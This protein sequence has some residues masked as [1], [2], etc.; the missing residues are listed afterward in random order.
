MEKCPDFPRTSFSIVW[1]KQFPAWES[2]V[3][4]TQACLRFVWMKMQRIYCWRKPSTVQIYT[5][6]SFLHLFS[7]SLFSTS[8]NGIF[9][10][11]SNSIPSWNRERLTIVSL[12]MVIKN[13]FTIQLFTPLCLECPLVYWGLI[14]RRRKVQF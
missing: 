8:K 5:V 6:K 3:D 10:Y 13:E 7:P 12:K 11:S 2:I 14:K 4:A 1:Y 9:F